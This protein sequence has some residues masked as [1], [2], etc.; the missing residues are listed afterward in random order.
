MS[1]ALYKHQFKAMGGPCQCHLWHDSESAADTLFETLEQEVLRLERKYSRFRTDSLI[2]KIN[3]GQFNGVRLDEET[4]GLLN[5]AQDCFE[6]SGH[7]FDLTVGSLR[8]V[9]DYN[10]G[11]LPEPDALNTLLSTV[12]WGRLGWDG[13]SLTVP[14]NMEL[15]LGGLVKE[16]AVDRLVGML[17][18]RQVSGLVNLAG[19]IAVSGPSLD[20]SAWKVAISHPREKGAIAWVELITGSIAGSGDYE[21][22]MIVDGVRYS[23]ILRPDTGYPAKNSL[24]SVSVIAD[25]CLLAGAVSTIAMLKGEHA[26]H[27]LDEMALPYLAFDQ[28]LKPFGTVEVQ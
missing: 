25:Q 12:G 9:W 24:S 6:L 20:G 13:H 27:W 19:D 21:R 7:V 4:T 17:N 23:H 2:S 26:Q 15:D 28:A 22:Y 11:S 3:T 18:E 8:K 10:S 5:F 1:V 16:F 14:D